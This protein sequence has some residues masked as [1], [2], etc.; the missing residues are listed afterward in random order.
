[1]THV[2]VLL[3]LLLRIFEPLNVRMI[4]SLSSNICRR[5]L[6]KMSD[7]YLSE[8]DGTNMFILKT[9]VHILGKT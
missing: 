7:D 1:M 6:E 5:I 9:I 3:R 2:V 4:A 8:S